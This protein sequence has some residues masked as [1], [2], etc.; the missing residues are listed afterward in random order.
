MIF[1]YANVLEGCAAGKRDALKHL[2][3]EEAGRLVAVAMRIVR[4]RELAE[5]V[6]HDAFIS[7]WNRSVSFDPALGSA[8]GWIYTVV[9]NRALNVVRDNRREDIAD[10]AIV[11]AAL[12]AREIVA[13]AFAQLADASRLRQCLERLDEKKR[14]SVMM[15]YVTGYSH[16]E[17]AGRLGVPLGTVKAW[18]K[19]GLASLKDCMA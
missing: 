12:D 1:D 18:V 2:Y 10:P 8:R 3:D 13:D 5:E 17:I 9:R 6:V 11:S 14:E 16:G 7:I 15:S 19:R 4:R